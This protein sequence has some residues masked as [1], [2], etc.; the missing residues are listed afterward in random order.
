MYKIDDETRNRII[1][2][3]YLMRYHACIAVLKENH[4]KHE[5]IPRRAFYLICTEKDSPTEEEKADLKY[6]IVE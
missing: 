6:A 2:E 3:N 1:S 4:I 5:S